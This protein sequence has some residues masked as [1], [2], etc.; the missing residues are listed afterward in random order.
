[1]VFFRNRAT[2]VVKNNIQY[3]HDPYLIFFCM[4]SKRLLLRSDMVL[5]IL[6]P[7]Y[8]FRTVQ[9][10]KAYSLLLVNCRNCKKD[11]CPDNL[12]CSKYGL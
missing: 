5:V 4:N 10:K 12:C 3:D 2:S 6:R 8:I 11:G 7:G 9:Q 1:M